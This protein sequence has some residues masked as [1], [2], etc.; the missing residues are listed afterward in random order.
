MKNI[1]S[2]LYLRESGMISFSDFHSKYCYEKIKLL[3]HTTYNNKK[4]TEG[5]IMEIICT[6][7]LLF[8]ITSLWKCICIQKA[9]FRL[10]HHLT[11][12]EERS[13]TVFY[14]IHQN[15]V[16]LVYLYEARGEE[17]L[18]CRSYNLESLENGVCEGTELFLGEDLRTPGFLEFDDLNKLVMTKSA[19][20]LEYK[21]WKLEDYSLSHCI[22]DPLVEEIRLSNDLCL[23]VHSPQTSSIICKLCS[24]DNGQIL[25]IYDISIKPYRLIELLEL[26]GCHLLVKQYGEPLLILNLLNHSIIQIPGF[27][28][29]QNFIYLHEKRTFLALRNYV[30]EV[31]NFG[32]KLLKIYHAPVY[33]AS[34]GFIPSRLHVS[35][36]QDLIILSWIERNRPSA[37]NSAQ[38]VQ[39][40]VIKVFKL[41]DGQ[42]I[43]EIKNQAVLENLTSVTYDESFGAIY[44]GHANGSITWWNN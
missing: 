8:A 20:T 21:F 14:N 22:N 2:T 11:K 37:R 27:L 26:F 44:T 29:P 9:S 19:A 42:L 39:N 36:T 31:W 3:N 32:G 43:K 28:S 38:V 6:Q 40:S 15:T 24:V 1:P 41:L 33:T 30:I 13:R 34:S 5:L 23:L 4:F 12:S 10:L 17:R 7:N 18:R 35:R 25:D 16:I